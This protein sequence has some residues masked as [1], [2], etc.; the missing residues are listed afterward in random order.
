MARKLARH[1]RQERGYTFRNSCLRVGKGSSK[2]EQAVA[3]TGWKSHAPSVAHQPRRTYGIQAANGVGSRFT[4][5]DTRAAKRPVKARKHEKAP[6]ILSWGLSSFW[7]H[8]GSIYETI[9]ACSIVAIQP[10]TPLSEVNDLDSS[11]M[12]IPRPLTS[13]ANNTVQNSRPLAS[14]LA[15]SYAILPSRI[16]RR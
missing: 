7:G 13:R 3:S 15:I 6:T 12:G 1:L 8:S 10:R 9:P 14:P 2:Q 11:R 5:Q 4:S 16:K